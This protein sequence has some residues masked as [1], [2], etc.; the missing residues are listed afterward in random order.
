VVVARTTDD[1]RNQLRER[2]F[3]LL[4]LDLMIPQNEDD[5]KLDLITLDAGQRILRELHENMDWITHPNCKIV[6]LSAQANL[7]ALAEITNLVG[8]FGCLIH[9]PTSEEDIVQV[10]REMSEETMND[11]KH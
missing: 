2:A 8:S 9:K 3:N 10:I 1:G 4:L 6:V 7:D 11:G 5:L